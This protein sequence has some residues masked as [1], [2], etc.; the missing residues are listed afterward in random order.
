MLFKQK[1]PAPS[2]GTGITS[3]A[4]V[5]ALGRDRIHP[6]R[7][8]ATARQGDGGG[9]RDRRGRVGEVP[10][11]HRAGDAAGDQQPPAR[12]EPARAPPARA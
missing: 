7:Q 4:N 3:S 10:H 1:N 2:T 5:A 12:T 6:V 8:Q 11:Q 9:G